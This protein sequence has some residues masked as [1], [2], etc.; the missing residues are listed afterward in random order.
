MTMR[1]VIYARYSSDLQ[2][3]RS[4]EDQ[5]RDCRA[6]ADRN[7]WQVLEV[8]ADHAISGAT[9]L[10]PGIQ[11]LLEHAGEARFDVVI[12]EALDRLSRD[13]SDTA[14]L[15]KLLGFH[16]VKLF[17]LSEGEVSQLHVGFKGTMN[18][19]FLAELALKI[20]R[21]QRGNIEKG[22]ASGGLSYGYV[23]VREFGPHGEPLR[24]RR[25]IN[26]DQAA[27]VRRIFADYVAGLTPLAIAR[28]LN[29]EGV[30]SMRG[31]KWRTSTI[32][33]H[34][35][36]KHGILH[37]EL[38]IG[39]LIGGRTSKAKDPRTSKEINRLHAEAQ[40]R[41]VP[42]PELRIVDDATWKAAHDV[43]RANGGGP[44]TATRR[45][46]SPHLLSDLIHCATCGARFVQRDAVRLTCSGFY[47]DGTCDN[48]RRVRRAW[49]EGRVLEEVAKLLADPGN[50]ARWTKRYHEAR[51]AQT[52]QARILMR[53]LIKELGDVKAKI[54]RLVDAIA[55]GTAAA[56]ASA[57]KLAADLERRQAE[58]ERAIA[59]GDDNGVVAL[60]PGA[61]RIYAQR[62]TA[63]A[64]AFRAGTVA[65]QARARE[66]LRR[67]IER[68]EIY[69]NASGAR[70]A[71]VEWK[72]VGKFGEILRMASGEHAANAAPPT[73]GYKMVRVEGDS[74]IPPPRIELKFR[75]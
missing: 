5:V 35:Q 38:Y 44:K 71:D 58:L 66:I 49:L 7:G 12:T 11:A 28:A 23:V 72:L 39:V 67:L 61:P 63:L 2:S 10:R 70:D 55:D 46:R 25:R 13:L 1:A 53:A 19:Q 54:A 40:W 41:R 74:Q 6:L 52:S 56:P 37:N 75:A 3:D 9:L 14:Q 69:P 60:E 27:V 24:G 50:V 45:R 30:P 51:A 73:W 17:T 57:L 15:Y 48:S 20:R 36:R 62:I 22:L 4:I 31:G 33:G 32:G 21:G 29:A 59:A 16:Q 68:V 42:V 43:K 18:A 26:D 64:E 47:Y 34:R 8:Y 65:H